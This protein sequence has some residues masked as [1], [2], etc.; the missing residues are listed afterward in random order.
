[1][2]GGSLTALRY[3]E[4]E[5]VAVKA[6]A[7]YY[8][9]ARPFLAPGAHAPRLTAQQANDDVLDL[10]DVVG[11]RQVE[12]RL[13][14]RV[15]I[16][17]ENAAAALEVMSR[18]AVDPRW[19]VYLPPTMSPP[20]TS[21]E[22]GYLE[23]PAEAL[24]YYRANGVPRVVVEEKH[25]GSRAV[26]IAG[27][28]ADAARKAFGVDDGSAGTVYTRTGRPFFEDRALATA[29]LDRVRGA[30]TAAGTWEA[31]ETD[32]VVLD[33]ELMPWSAKAQDLI[34]Q[35]YAPVGVAALTSLPQVAEA[36]DA[37]AARGV[38]VGPMPARARERLELVERYVAA[39][40]RYA[41]PVAGL[42]DLRLAP[43]H[44]LASAGKVHVDR[45]HAWHMDTLAE[46]CRQDPGLLVAT[47]YRVVDVTDAESTAAAVAW[48]DELTGRGGEGMVVKPLDFLPGRAAKGSRPVQPAV[49]C[50]G[51]EYLRIIYGPEYTL[52]EHLERL[53]ERGLGGKRSFAH[54]EFAIGI[55]GLER[56]VRGE[57]LRRV[58]ECAFAVLALESEPVDPRL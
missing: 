55:E 20:E 56:F 4:R 33:S 3:P 28:D 24:A 30:L 46:V 19:L 36:L 47:L 32:W 44:L 11:K 53:R 57:P 50:R 37:A 13:A 5:L 34:R 1:V 2:F 43:F 12:T 51:R 29:F 27:R 39:Y 7:T 31:L 54:R 38:D 16:R 35:Q 15:T 22:P 14:G 23:H 18:F 48:W 21:R 8:E 6:R 49:K 9:P 42:G 25:M 10:A 26:V 41:W 45:D 40:Q 17:E 58:H 52:P